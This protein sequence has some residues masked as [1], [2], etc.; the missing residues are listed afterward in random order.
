MKRY[1]LANAANAGP[2]GG[3][4]QPSS[5]ERTI[6]IDGNRRDNNQK[7]TVR[8]TLVKIGLDAKSVRDR[9]RYNAGGTP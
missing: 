2:K 9:I 3:D 4:F 1:L 7:E 5:L 8:R 6:E